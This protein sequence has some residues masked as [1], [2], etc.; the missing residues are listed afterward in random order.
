[1]ATTAGAQ[2]EPLPVTIIG[3]Y[4]G[5]GKTTLVN[6][7][8]RQANGRRLAIMVNEFGALPIDRDL[9]EAEDDTI[10][11]LAGG[12]VCCSYGEDLVSSMVMLAGMTP[13][14]DHVLLEASGVA[15]PGA[16]AGTVGLLQEFALDGV[17]VLADADTVQARAD[18]KYLGSTIRRQLADADLILLNKTDLVADPVGVDAWVAS[19]APAARRVRSIQCAVPLEA[20]LGVSP[21]DGSAASRPSPPTDHAH[22]ADGYATFRFDPEPIDD[23][24]ALAAQLAAPALGLLRAKGFVRSAEGGKAAIQIVGNRWSVSP[25]AADV[26]TGLVCIGMRDSV[27]GPALSAIF[28]HN[29]QDFQHDER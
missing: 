3:G 11:T 10:I 5:A 9:I 1:M 6:N 26:P 28:D 17:I 25:A 14:P 19:V 22:H 24:A 4:L 20:V 13:R 29:E 8:L 16:I 18:D 27:D 12:C 7:L 2:L 15:F 23:P 21:H